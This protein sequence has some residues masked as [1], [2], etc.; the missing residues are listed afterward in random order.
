V[1][2]IVDVDGNILFESAVTNDGERIQI[3]LP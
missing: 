1:A 2:R 3:A